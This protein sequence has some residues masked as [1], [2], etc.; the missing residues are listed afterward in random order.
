[1]RQQIK[2]KKSNSNRI[3]CGDPHF[4]DNP[5]DS[6]RWDFLKW[7]R[8]KIIEL[9]IEKL[10]IL[11]D[12]CEKKNYHSSTLVNRIIYE[13]YELSNICEIIILKGN[14]DYDK[15]ENNP[16][17]QFSS[18]LNKITY[19]SN[20][21]Q[22]ASEYFIPHSS[23][24]KFCAD[25]PADIDFTYLH[26]D[27]IGA[28]VSNDYLL[29]NGIKIES[30]MHKKPYFI[31]GHVHIP[32]SIGSN[33]IYVGAPYPI[34]FGDIYVGRIVFIDSYNKIKSIDYPSIKKWSLKINSIDEIND[35]DL[36]KEDQVKI[37]INILQSDYHRWNDIKNEIKSLCEKLEIDLFSVTIKP[38]T[39][40]RRKRLRQNNNIISP[41]DILNRFTEQEKLGSELLEVGKELL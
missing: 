28:K 14:H 36:E 41:E 39:K 11:G 20:P 2:I 10:Y 35:Y 22:I 6:Y 37:E 25:I 13:L 18:K 3:I 5:K 21:C 7:L 23:S 4:T 12:I 32:Q 19:I 8:K 30:L 29:E 27:I 34:K 31:S 38:I 24:E 26:H 15:D 16:F 33:F 40:K 1:M 17:F 9:N